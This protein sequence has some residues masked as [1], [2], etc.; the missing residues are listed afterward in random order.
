VKAR[1]AV[2]FVVLATIL[3]VLC[4]YGLAA[5]HASNEPAALGPG[6]VTVDL[7]TRYSRF[8]SDEIVVHQ[9]TLV[10]FVITNDDP[11][12]HEFI[13]GPP[14]VHAAHEAG[15]DLVHPPIPGE[16]SVDPGET[17]LTTYLF[18]TPGTVRF[19]CHF[20]G[21]LVYGMQ[22]VVKVLAD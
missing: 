22:G 4:G 19:A 9:G 1:G 11:I 2:V 10:E 14:E 21:H 13:V 5:A 6:L 18:D 7:T 3:P 8:S 20:P 12:H 15:H 17:G 16:V